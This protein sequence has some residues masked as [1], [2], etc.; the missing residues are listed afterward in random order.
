MIQK[1]KDLHAKNEQL[2]R[3]FI[4]AAILVAVEYGSYLVMLWLGLQYLVA[5]P[6]SMAI[7][8]IL[9]WYCSRVFVFKTRRHAPHKEFMLVLV[10][11]LIGVGIQTLVTFLVVHGG[12]TPAVGKLLAILVT[13]F[14]NYFVRKK[15]IF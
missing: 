4:M 11:S 9:N 8:I 13:F 15:Y 6:L 5:V 12:S 3:Y 10:A 7:G 14:W 1:I 2:V